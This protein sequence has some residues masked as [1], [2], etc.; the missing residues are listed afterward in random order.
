MTAFW[1]KRLVQAG[2]T[3]PADGGAMP[4]II[5][6]FGC[7][8]AGVLVGGQVIAAALPQLPE[9]TAVHG[10]RRMRASCRE[11]RR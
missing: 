5:A 7:T 9:I 4:D 6:G 8:P 10:A 1:R 11:R 2:N 3:F